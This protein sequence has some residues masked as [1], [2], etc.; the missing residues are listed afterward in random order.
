MRYK[1]KIVD[2]KIYESMV[3]KGMHPVLSSLFASRDISSIDDVDYK[4]DKL[5]PPDLLKSVQE[6]SNL[7]IKNT[8]SNV[9]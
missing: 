8:Y 1:E 4:L 6:A 9:L 7:I 5:I 3:N 2:S